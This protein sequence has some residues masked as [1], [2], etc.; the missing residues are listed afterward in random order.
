M[1]CCKRRLP[2]GKA[3]SIGF[4]V[5]RELTARFGAEFNFDSVQASLDMRNGASASLDQTRASF[6][7]VFS[8]LFPGGAASTMTLA[9]ARDI[10]QDFV[11]GTVNVNLGAYGPARPYATAGL[12]AVL[13]R[14]EAPS[15][16]IHGSYVFPSTGTALID[17]RDLVVVRAVVKDKSLVSVVGGGVRLHV[18]PRQGVRADFR[19][20]L[21][22]NPIDTAVDATPS[23]VTQPSLG[24]VL[25]FPTESLAAIQLDER[26]AVQPERSGGQWTHDVCR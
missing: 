6:L 17:E 18:S 10:R 2:A 19:V 7:A 16:S 26:P 20:H 23:L 15:A 9:P 3:A 25:V 22:A 21:T 5:G 12:G 11:T 14:G 4:R 24:A 1:D 8:S 13:N